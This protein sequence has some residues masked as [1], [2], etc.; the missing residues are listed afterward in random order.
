MSDVADLPPVT[1]VIEWE[2][3]VDTEAAWAQRAVAALQHEIEAVAPR[4]SQK[5][6]VTYL[7][8]QNVVD[9][10]AI[11][12]NIA[13]AAPRLADIAALEIV[14]TAG[15]TYYELKNYGVARAATELSIILDSDAVPQ[16]GWLEAI[17]APFADPSVMAV[18][19]ITVM[20]YEDLLSRT[21]A[22]SWIFGL[23]EERTRTA[24]KQGIYA[25]NIA[26]RTAFLR[27]NPFPQVKAFKKACVVWLRDITARGHR[28]V[29]VADAVTIHAPHP[30]YNFVLWRAWV[31]GLDRDFHGY[32][33][34][35]HSLSG[36]AA[37]ALRFFAQRLGRSWRRIL[38]KRRSVEL[39][40]W[41]VPAAMGIALGFF[42]TA[43]AG[44]MFSIATR[45]HEALPVDRIA[46][47]LG[48]QQ[49]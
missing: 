42:L 6:A 47:P 18:G 25:N 39:P 10:K 45:R 27:D 28:Y 13:E 49:V 7:Y 15:L 29:R 30:G 4:M 31:T 48:P 24:A 34:V 12:R 23:A 1:I 16:P 21:M 35:S 43:F 32:H 40:A 11:R 37:F 14:P 8:E 26:V 41:Q 20:G 33:F 38:T 19:G 2:N 3:A 22:L 46:P 5:P 44:Q 17:C 9:P 36:R